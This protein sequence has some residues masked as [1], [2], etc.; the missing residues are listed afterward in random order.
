MFRF[1]VV[2]DLFILTEVVVL[3]FRVVL[4][5]VKPFQHLVRNLYIDMCNVMHQTVLPKDISQISGG[6]SLVWLH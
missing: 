1:I 2:V 6:N 4:P 3:K 5:I